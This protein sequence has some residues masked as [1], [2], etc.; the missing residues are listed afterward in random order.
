MMWFYFTSEANSIAID[1]GYPLTEGKGF[2][3]KCRRLDYFDDCH[4]L[5]YL[6]PKMTKYIKDKSGCR[7]NSIWEIIGPEFSTSVKEACGDRG[8]TPNALP[9]KTLGYCKNWKDYDCSMAQLSKTLVK[10]AK[11]VP[12]EKL[13][14]SGQYI[15]QLL[16]SEASSNRLFIV[17]FSFKSP[18]TMTLN[19]EYYI[20]PTLDLIGI[21]GGTLGMFIGFSFYGTYSDI[22]DIIQFLASKINCKGK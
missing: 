17:M 9:N 1:N 14:Y 18:Y 15:T 5:A 10:H 2:M 3:A 12:C 7:D 11:T 6:K 4:T 13:E 16:S 21:I 8:C 20:V 19:E 22:I